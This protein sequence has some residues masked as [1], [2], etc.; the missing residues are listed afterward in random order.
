MENN[1]NLSHSNNL[2]NK[3]KKTKTIF[4][5]NDDSANITLCFCPCNCECH[6]K[7]SQVNNYDSIKYINNPPSNL[8]KHSF[9][10][11]VLNPPKEY[12]FDYNNNT[13]IN[14]RITKESL[15]KKSYLFSGSDNNKTEEYGDKESAFSNQGYGMPKKVNNE[16]IDSK[17]N[18]SNNDNEYILYRNDITDFNKFIN[19]LHEIKNKEKK[20]NRCFSQKEFNSKYSYNNQI[21]NNKNNNYQYEYSN[22]NDNLKNNVHNDYDKG[23]FYNNNKKKGK[24]L[25]VDFINNNKLFRDISNTNKTS[26]NKKLKNNL[27]FNSINVNKFL[28]FSRTDKNKLLYNNSSK[29]LNTTKFSTSNRNYIINQENKTDNNYYKEDII[30]ENNPNDYSYNFNYSQKE[31]PNEKNNNNPLGHIVDNF[32]SMLKYK[33]NKAPVPCNDLYNINQCNDNIIKRKKNLNMGLIKEKP[34]FTYQYQYQSKDLSCFGNRIKR[35]EIYKKNIVG[36]R[37]IKSKKDEFEKKYGKNFNDINYKNKKCDDNSNNNSFSYGIYDNNKLYKFSKYADGKNSKKNKN[38]DNNPYREN[39]NKSYSYKPDKNNN[40]NKENNKYYF[41]YSSSNI[42]D[43]N[44]LSDKNLN[45]DKKEENSKPNNYTNYSKEKG[46]NKFKIEAFDIFIQD[47][48]NKIKNKE[49]NYQMNNNSPS[50]QN[51]TIEIQSLSKLTYYPIMQSG[52]SEKNTIMSKQEN[53]Q[54]EKNLSQS[55]VVGNKKRFRIETVP[56]KVRKLISKKAKLNLKNLKLSSKLNLDTNLTLSEECKKNCENLK[57]NIALNPKSIFTIYE[58]C[59]KPVVLAFDIENKTFSFQDFYDFGNF[60]ENFKLSLNRGNLYIT[61]DTNLYIITGKNHDMLYMFD[62]IKKT[63]NKLCNLKN[64]HSNGSLLYFE[65]NL[66]CL[67]GDHNKIVEMY[68]I[69]KNEWTYLP[70]MLIERSNSASCLMNN[71]DNRYIFNLFGY[72]SK[73]KIYLN[74]IEY[75]VINKKDFGWKYLRYNNPSGISLNICNLFCFCNENKIII[76]GGNNEK[77]NKNN[78]KYILINFGKDFEKDINIKYGDKKIGNMD[79]NQKYYFEKGHKRFYDK[80]T[81]EVF[82]EIFDNE[83]NCH[84]FKENDMSH[85]LF[86]F[87]SE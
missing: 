18:A 67:S 71:K 81:N 61:I 72:N 11:N 41:D 13:D 54:K 33:K 51:K 27:S 40:S 26:Q 38:I 80:D 79:I 9:S 6:N 24:I 39:E 7:L 3:Q 4:V 35:I 52:H 75:L 32:V 34:K 19:T 69:N 45:K 73:T 30:N 57:R 53:E 66:I 15:D 17:S 87:Q 23:K 62:S 21:Q 64:N 70:E 37:E 74:T 43:I 29:D 68:S 85:D 31:N 42:K 2:P 77:E 5:K 22:Q 44:D 10:S 55:M 63:M 65:N 8:K 60:E 76:F 14:Q 86:Y 16:I 12:S 59:I 78:D 83:Y 58:N 47:K 36:K 48:K 50:K 1:N 25:S 84:L 20:M 28:N 82:Y 49:I 56:E 46:T